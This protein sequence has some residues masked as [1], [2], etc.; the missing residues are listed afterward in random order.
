[1]RFGLTFTFALRLALD[2]LVFYLTIRL[3]I[4]THHPRQ[5]QASY[6]HW[7]HEQCR[8]N[9]IGQ[10]P[11]PETHPALQFGLDF[12]DAFYYRVA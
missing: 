6:R 4:R 9:G 2:G 3:G 10:A 12:A 8:F 11:L 5:T 1:L 7:H